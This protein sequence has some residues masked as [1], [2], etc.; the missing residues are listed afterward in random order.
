MTMT[1]KNNP[2]THAHQSMKD[3]SAEM[4]IPTSILR[5][6]KRQGAPGFVGSRIRPELLM[7]W[8]EENQPAAGE[9]VI[10]KEQAVLMR[11]LEQVRDLRRKNDEQEGLLIARAWVQERM[12]AACST[13]IRLRQDGKDARC[14]TA[15]G[16]HGAPVAMARSLYDQVSADGGEVLRS[17][18]EVFNE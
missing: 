17:L 1:T 10:A 18:A 6:A 14:L 12:G 2:K 13:W 7:P 11:V 15:S 8:L 9:P 3:A 16:Q 4:G 5:W